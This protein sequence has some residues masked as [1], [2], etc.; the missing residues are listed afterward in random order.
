M[1]GK[2]Q[3][4]GLVKVN[5][6]VR[7]TVPKVK[8]AYVAS[9]CQHCD[10]APCITVCKSGAISKRDDGLVIIDPAKCSGKQLCVDACPYGAIYFNQ[11]LKVAQKCTGCAHLL[12]RGWPIKEPRCTDAC[13]SG[14]L[15]FGEEGEC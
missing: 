2:S 13:I 9:L 8:L 6:Y 10:N 1:P 7:G 14:G 5:E 15:M 12:D 3:K 4:R 11:G